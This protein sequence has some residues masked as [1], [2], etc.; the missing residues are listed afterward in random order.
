MSTLSLQ[1]VERDSFFTRLDFRPKMLMM[2]VLTIIAFVWESPVMGGLLALG[3]ILA[4]LAVGVKFSYIR[5]IFSI[6]IPFYILLIVTQG[7]FANAL[8]TSLTGKTE[9]Q[10]VMLF[11]FPETWFWVGGAGM[12]WEGVQYALNI[13]AKTLTMTLVI[14]LAIFTTDVNT[15]IVGMVKARLPYKLAFIFS[16]TLRFFPLLF[17]EIQSIIEAQ[18]LR[19]LAFEKMGPVKRVRVYAKVAVPLILGAM[20]KSQ[21]LEVVLQSKAFSG[22]ADR[23]YLHE[24]HLGPEDYL[25]FVFFTL[26]FIAAIIAYFAWGVGKF[27]GPI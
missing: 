13:V 7:F 19:G 20:V 21:M 1:T 26:F 8:I 22:S 4:C 27:G 16:S 5:M 24:S 6:M 9:D 12:S 18:R 14:P 17:E 15:M 23:T 25:L 2:A 3:V 11:R 10:F